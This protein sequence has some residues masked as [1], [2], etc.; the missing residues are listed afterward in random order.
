MPNVSIDNYN[1]FTAP[2]YFDYDAMLI[3]P[4]NI[5]R[6]VRGLIVEGSAFEG[7]DGRPV[8]NGPS[9]ASS[10]AA[11][12]L[13]KRRA[14]ETQRLLEAGGAVVV[15]ARP[16]ATQLGLLGFEGCDRYSWLP[17]PSGVSWS[18]PFLRAGEGQ[19]VRIV[20]EDHALT[21]VLRNFRANIRYRAVFDERSESL[22]QHGR[23]IA[24]GGANV[25]I[26]VEFHVLGGT[27][28]FLPAFTDEMGNVRSNLAEALVDGIRQVLSD[29]PSQPPYF[30]QSIAV[31][32]LAVVESDLADIEREA[33]ALGERVESGRARQRELAS[34]RDLLWQDGAGFTAALRRVVTMLGFSVT[35]GTGEPLEVEA[36]GA[37]AYVEFEANRGVVVEWPYV[38]LQRRLEER[39]LKRGDQLKGIVVVNGFRE[40][41]PTTR[42]Q[43]YTDALCTACEN[44]RYC[45]VTG[46]TLFAISLAIIEGAGPD[47]LEGIRRRML[48]TNGLLT[49]AR[50][51]GTAE[52]TPGGLF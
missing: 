11:A 16:N 39:L 22:R 37:R 47:I 28:I 1:V 36:D 15:I 31:P 25:P 3:D 34:H 50:A 51:L 6:M 33:T 2:S 20:N 17:A 7:F 19:T 12:E 44:Y 43:Q 26:A 32:G 4:D 23:T 29:V 46:E 10:V 30:A 45:L 40:S 38:R 41:E 8:V 5:T 18:P 9:D 52:E 13:I 24:A 21:S 27:V 35:S 49:T 48:R 42:E 14:D